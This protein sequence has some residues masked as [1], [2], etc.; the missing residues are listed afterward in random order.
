MRR[1]EGELYGSIITLRN[2]A[3]VQK[4]NA[5]SVSLLERLG[6]SWEGQAVLEGIQHERYLYFGENDQNN[7]EQ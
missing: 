5:A 3:L 4:E 7:S 1:L 6:F 2:L